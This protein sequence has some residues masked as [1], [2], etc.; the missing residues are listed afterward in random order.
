M[1]PMVIAVYR[2]KNPSRPGD[3]AV[4]NRE[5]GFLIPKESLTH[6]CILW[7]LTDG[8]EEKPRLE[9]RYCEPLQDIVFREKFV[10]RAKVKVPW[11]AVKSSIKQFFK[12]PKPEGISWK[13]AKEMARAGGHAGEEDRW[14]RLREHR[15]GTAPL[16]R[17][18]PAF[19]HS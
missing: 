19:L 4:W 6:G 9:M 14:L 15:A 17:D 5:Q 8:R 16:L 1:H 10:R 11:S 7:A 2:K 18:A 3:E 12:G 13:K